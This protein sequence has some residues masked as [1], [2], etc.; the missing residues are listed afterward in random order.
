MKRVY[1]THGY[2]ATGKVTTKV[3]VYAYGVILMEMITGRKVLDDSLP[4]DE[5]HLVTIFKR[6]MI[7]KQKFRKFVDPTLEL[8]AESWNSLL[9]IADLAHHCTSREPNPRP[10]MCHC[11]NRLSSLVDQWKPTNI[12]EDDEC[13]TSEMG[14][15][16]QLERWRRNDFTISDSDSFSTYTSRNMADDSRWMY[17]GWDKSGDKAHSAEWRRKT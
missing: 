9:E 5:A 3:D 4:E 8:S 6:N 11:V 17:D 10:D 12:V 13:G 7:D 14:L 15:H 16:E 1:V 2:A